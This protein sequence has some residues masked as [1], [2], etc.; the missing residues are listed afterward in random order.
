LQE[1]NRTTRQDLHAETFGNSEVIACTLVLLKIIFRPRYL[2]K[3]ELN[4]AKI[5]GLISALRSHGSDKVLDKR[6]HAKL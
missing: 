5:P 4:K 2:D 6:E 1:H 3:D